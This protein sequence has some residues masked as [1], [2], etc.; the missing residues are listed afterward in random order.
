MWF[1]RIIAHFNKIASYTFYIKGSDRIAQPKNV[2]D[3]ARTMEMWADKNIPQNL[4]AQISHKIAEDGFNE[5]PTG[6][7]NWYLSNEADPNQIAQYIK[8]VGREMLSPIGIAI[9]NIRNETSQ[10]FKVPVV[11]VDVIKN[12]TTSRQQLP[13]LNI[14][15]VNAE[16]LFQVLKIVPSMFGEIDAT[17]LL[18]RIQEAE[19]TFE[20]YAR[21]PTD[22]Q[23][24]EKFRDFGLSPEKISQYLDVLVQMSNMASQMNDPIVAWRN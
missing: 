19:A 9:G 5:S 11:R 6:T 22:P 8:Q 10:M 1:K 20:A 21:Q 2:Q 18:G 23:S 16:A 13:N 4:F 15:N 3:I 12:F 7:I 17:E 24:K 14:A